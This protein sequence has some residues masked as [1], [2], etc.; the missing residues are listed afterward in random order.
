MTD[1]PPDPFDHDALPV[2]AARNRPE[3]VTEPFA[4]T[5]VLAPD[6]DQG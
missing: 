2:L 3:K 6:G 1:L 5:A 4:Y